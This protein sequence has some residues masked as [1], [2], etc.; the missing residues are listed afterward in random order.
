MTCSVDR[1]G[2]KAIEGL[3]LINHCPCRLNKSPI[4]SFGHPILL[5]SIE[6]QKFMLVAFL[7]KIIFNLNV[8]EL[9]AIVTF[10]LLD[11]GIKLIL[12]SLKEL[13]EH[14]LC[15]I[16]VLQKE[17]LSETRII[18]NNY[19]PIFVTANAN[20]G[21]RTKQVHIKHLQGSFSCHDILGIMR[22]S[23]LLSG[24]TCSTWP[25]FLKNNIR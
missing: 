20:V 25:I 9:G 1:F 15:F 22:W 5:W 8:L 4:L 6:C 23:H 14:L 16:L 24:L 2:P 17:Y 12:R 11:F 7:I 18:I 13:L 19:N 3:V 21:D 10:Y